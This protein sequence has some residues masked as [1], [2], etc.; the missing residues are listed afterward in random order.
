METT[1]EP[2]Y[3]DELETI[4]LEFIDE[5]EA[6]KRPT[7][8]S[9]TQRYPQYVAQLT[10]FVLDFLRLEN[11]TKNVPLLETASPEAERGMA[12]AMAALGFAT[13]EE[14]QTLTEARKA[15]GMTQA[16]L[17][18][19]LHLPASIIIQIERGQAAQWGQ[20]LVAALSEALGISSQQSEATLS[21]TAQFTY[22]GAQVA[23]S[24]RE[25]P[26]VAS[27]VRDRQSKHSFQEILK[28]AQLSDEQAAYWA[29]DLHS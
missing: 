14:A 10:D 26:D 11:A 15:K 18:R 9:Y 5:H 28:M 29:E 20:K 17:A 22:G 2:T 4:R 3:N 8:E 24:A 7:L 16:A 27:L 21:R 23:L 1:T 25:N 6:G 13:Q 12:K 19:L